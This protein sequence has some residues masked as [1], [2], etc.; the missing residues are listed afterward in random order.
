MEL[1]AWTSVSGT[2]QIPD[3]SVMQS[4]LPPDLFWRFLGREA[5]QRRG[6]AGQLRR[7][8]GGHALEPPSAR[9]SD[10]AIKRGC[11]LPRTSEGPRKAAKAEVKS[12]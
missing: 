1:V 12:E 11:D 8:R 9:T 6:G 10:G 3:V 7:L 5:V 4:G 2:Y